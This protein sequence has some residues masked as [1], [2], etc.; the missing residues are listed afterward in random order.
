MEL[1]L[2][3]P[4]DHIPLILFHKISVNMILIF[5]SLTRLTR[6]EPSSQSSFY[7]VRE[8]ERPSSYKRRSTGNIL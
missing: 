7:F 2:T 8:A 1:T 4:W 6:M 3:Y 5:L